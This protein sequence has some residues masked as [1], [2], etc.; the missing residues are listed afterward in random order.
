M[1]GFFYSIYICSKKPSKSSPTSTHLNCIF[2]QCLRFQ[3][4]V[5]VGLR[6]RLRVWGSGSP[7]EER[8]VI[9]IPVYAPPLR[10]P[11]ARAG[12]VAPVART[13]QGLFAAALG[14]VLLVTLCFKP[15][16]A[17]YGSAEMMNSSA[18]PMQE[19]MFP[20]FI[21]KCLRNKTSRFYPFSFLILYEEVLQTYSQAYFLRIN[22]IS[23]FLN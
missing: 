13:A 7:R 1:W 18:E 11:A 3:H 19:E 4:G 16:F 22:V 9:A 8:G 2:L 5:S 14:R 15:A 6:T 23:C 10:R 21:G 20:C 17:N 12:T